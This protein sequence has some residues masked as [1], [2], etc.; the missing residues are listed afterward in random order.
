[1]SEA[2]LFEW[3]RRELALRADEDADV[4]T[5]RADIRDVKRDR[6]FRRRRAGLSRSEARD[7]LDQATMEWAA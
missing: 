5:G 6:S 1:M 2:D 7:L 4:A 3:A